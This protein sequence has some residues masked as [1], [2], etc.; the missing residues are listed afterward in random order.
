MK[1]IFLVEDDREIARNLSLLLRSE[2]FEVFHAP[3]RQ[4]A[5]D[6]LGGN[7]FDLALVDISLPDGNG[8][9]LCAEIKGAQ[10]IPVLFLTAS[11]DEASV[12]TG[13]NMGADDYIT[14][15]FDNK[16]LV[17]RVKTLWRRIRLTR[18]AAEDA[19]A[20]PEP[21]PESRVL[22]HGCL[23]LDPD[24]HTVLV[25]G[26]EVS[27]TFREF[28]LLCYLMRNRRRVLKREELLENIWGYSYMGNT[29]AVDI[30]IQRLRQKLGP[31]GEYVRTVYGVGYRFEGPG[32]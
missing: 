4:A 31:A 19:A 17:L 10:D 7:R 13:L 1:Q 20:P 2:G 18:G 3:T 6:M 32:K 25:E 12:V 27:L 26:E 23:T 22:A 11:G 28:D 9:S 15:P 21:E 16:E 30:L 14:K 29:R 8:F 5:V 24:A